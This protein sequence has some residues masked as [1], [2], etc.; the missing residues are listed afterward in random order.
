[1]FS[2]RRLARKAA[3][4]LA[5]ALVLGT[6]QVAA[7]EWEPTE[8]DSLIVEIRAGSYTLGGMVR[9]YQTTDGVCI[10]LADTVQALD[11][12]LRVDPKSRRATGWIFSEDNTLTIDRD[13]ATARTRNGTRTLRPDEIYDTPEGWCVDTR[14]LSEWFGAT[15][16]FDM[17]SLSVVIE[18]DKP[19][20]FLEAL[21][22]KSRAA[23]LRPKPKFDISQL[24]HAEL[25]YR[26][27]RTPA[28]DVLARAKVNGTAN[29]STST[30][31]R[32]E[33]YAS[34]EI[35]GASFNAR[36]A[37][38]RQGVPDSLRLRAFRTDPDGGLLGPLGA[39]QVA[40]GDVQLNAGQLTAQTAVGRG[41]FVSNRPIERPS[42]FGTTAL[43]GA[44]PAGWDAELYRNGQLI[45]WQQS[46]ADGRYEFLDVALLFGQNLLEVVL[47]GPQGQVRRDTSTIPVGQ[48]SIPEGKTYY[49]AGAVEKDRDLIRIGDD[50]PGVGIAGGGWRWGVGVERGIDKRTMVGL[51]AYSLSTLGERRD[52]IEGNVQRTL[53]PAVLSVTAAQQFGGG[54]AYSAQALGQFGKLNFQAQTLWLDGE[55]QSEVID[56][57]TRREHSV[58]F[59]YLMPTGARS[60][61]PLQAGYRRAS[62]RD[63]TTVNEWTGRASLMMR[64]ISL[65]AGVTQRSS[66]GPSE[67][68]YRNGTILDL[69]GNTSVGRV[70]LRG[71][72]KWRVSGA[73][74]GFEEAE[75][76]AETRLTD[77][78]DLRAGVAYDNLQG[79]T[80]FSAGYVHQFDRFA[81][82]ADA[83]YRTD[84]SFGFGVSLAFSLG[85][86]PVG[87]GLRV[88]N[89]K[90]A[91]KG[92]AAVTVFLDENGDGKRQANE[93]PLE[94]VSVEA[95]MLH[96]LAPT[97]AEGRTV[98]DGLPPYRP[99]TVSIDMA[100]LPDPLMQPTVQGVVVSPRPGVEAEIQ[101]AL[102]PSGEIEGTL[103]SADGTPRGGVTLELVDARGLVIKS[104]VS[105]FDGFFLFDQVA[106]GRYAIR[107]AES[108]AEAL[109]VPRDLGIVAELS[110]GEDLVVLGFVRLGE[111]ADKS[112]ATSKTT[113]S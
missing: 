93:K 7:Q 87:G 71:A 94:G 49:W 33:A 73:E 103:L 100:T 52:Y 10:D 28:V 82:R 68:R 67:R 64:G 34:G 12:A 84:K 53:G 15:V 51:G 76:S 23:R 44:L 90:L 25:P 66:S 72:G 65:T 85:R 113:G 17:S 77:R 14:T 42:Q 5:A 89:E 95:G 24:P 62:L 6:G 59:D 58:L 112:H 75:L 97:D 26:D 20:P 30:E 83:T 107:L 69:L 27:W 96:S 99:V 2:I 4:T 61:L 29:G 19:L 106:Y 108:S 40:V 8:D 36:L 79:R 1:M 37:S 91:R 45:A 57:N 81:V 54:R 98:I 9:G 41:A 22:R 11:V 63:G 55:Y 88:S 18:S 3:A 70:R 56:A 48:E 74:A 13:S 43:T 38:D 104:I 109:E 110:Q 101:L 47:Y 32:Y 16:R 80:A 39:T 105:E 21:E 35:L 46:R 111:G 92:S 50:A 78:S 102:A 86:D 60:S 31:F